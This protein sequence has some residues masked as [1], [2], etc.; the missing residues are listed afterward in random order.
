MKKFF[1]GIFLGFIVCL[2]FTTSIYGAVVLPDIGDG[3]VTEASFCETSPVIGTPTLVAQTYN[4]TSRL[5]KRLYKYEKVLD[6]PYEGDNLY[7]YAGGGTSC[8]VEYTFIEQRSMET[9]ITENMSTTH[10]ATLS[11]ELGVEG[12]GKAGGAVSIGGT[13]GESHAISESYFTSIGK[14]YN[15]SVAETAVRGYYRLEARIKCY[16]YYVVE[17]YYEDTN[18]CKLTNSYFC[19]DTIGYAYIGMM[20]YQY[21]SGLQAYLYSDNKDSG[22]VYL[23]VLDYRTVD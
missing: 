11:A 13:F 8:S 2:C 7:Y 20:R 1:I 14:T 4:G 9:V 6:V 22:C 15:F 19:V 16:L 10:N 21:D 23:T 17:Y 3:Y 5:K 12:V 18:H